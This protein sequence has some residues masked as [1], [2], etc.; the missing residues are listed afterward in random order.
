MP[1]GT[2]IG[3]LGSLVV[4]MAVMSF[5]EPIGRA[6]N[7]VF[8]FIDFEGRYIVLTLVIAGLIMITVSTVIRAFMTDFVGQART[9]QVQSAFNKEMRQAKLENNLFK[10][11]KLQEIQPKMTASSMENSTKMMKTMPVTMVVILPV[12]AWIRYFVSVTAFDAG[13]TMIHIPWDMG[14]LNIDVTA[15]MW[16]MPIWIIIYTM[17]SLPIGQLENRIVRWFLLKKRLKELESEPYT[18]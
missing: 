9:T 17:I 7:T 1:K 3:M 11:K 18:R 10:L 15:T 12:Y 14:T 6:L 16:I 4:M 13:S 5:N 8:H 2:M